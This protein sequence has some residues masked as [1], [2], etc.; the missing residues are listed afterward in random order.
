M[1]CSVVTLNG[2]E[3][4]DSWEVRKTHKLK[5]FRSMVHDRKTGRIIDVYILAKDV[6]EADDKAVK[7]YGGCLETKTVYNG[8]EEVAGEFIF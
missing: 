3:I 2:K 6:E 4:S 7:R 1:R 5:L 8:R